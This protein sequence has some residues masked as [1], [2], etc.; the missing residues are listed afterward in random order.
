MLTF[1]MSF[2]NKEKM[3]WH[4]KRGFNI[5]AGEDLHEDSFFSP[6]KQFSTLGRNTGSHNKLRSPE[7]YETAKTK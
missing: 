4:M 7:N 3:A 5:P 1:N 6:I 2:Q